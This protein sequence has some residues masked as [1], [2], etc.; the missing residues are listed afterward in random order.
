MGF[1]PPVKM[2]QLIQKI[3]LAIILV[4]IALVLAKPYDEFYDPKD[5]TI[6]EDDVEKRG[7]T[8]ERYIDIFLKFAVLALCSYYEI[9][10][11]KLFFCR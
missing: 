1:F 4:Q 11:L 8:Y 10:V 6:L 7:G 2:P 9:E 5:G 3:L